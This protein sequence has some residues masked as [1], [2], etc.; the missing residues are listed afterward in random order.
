MIVYSGY[1]VHMDIKCGKNNVIPFFFG[2]GGGTF[3][4]QQ[5]Y[6][7]FSKSSM[8]HYA[9]LSSSRNLPIVDLSIKLVMSVQ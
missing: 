1:S 9:T 8:L 4:I 3:A 2:G 7:N 6:S 5:E